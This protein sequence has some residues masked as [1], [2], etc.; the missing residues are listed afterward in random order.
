MNNNKEI[1]DKIIDISNYYKNMKVDLQKVA[2]HNKVKE[3]KKLLQAEEQDEYKWICD[4]CDYKCKASGINYN[5]NK[6][7]I[8]CC[9]SITN[10]IKT[11]WHPVR[12]GVKE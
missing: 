3:L 6:K 7:P 11:N 8:S 10:I 4:V 2:L 5:N 1:L 12:K 9:C